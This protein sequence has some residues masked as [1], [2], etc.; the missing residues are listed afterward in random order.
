MNGVGGHDRRA[1]V[2]LRRGRRWRGDLDCAV[3]DVTPIASDERFKGG[4]HGLLLGCTL[5]VFMYNVL[6]RNRLNTLIYLGLIL[7]EA[8][9]VLGHLDAANGSR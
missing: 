2:A 7:W 3:R 9:Q 4:I 8:H 1:R 6:R 5:P